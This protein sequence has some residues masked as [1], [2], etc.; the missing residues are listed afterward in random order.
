MVAEPGIHRISVTTLGDLLDLRAA[1]LGE[2]LAL[3]FP[4]QQVSYA[5]LAGRADFFARGLLAAGL[6]PGETVGI[7]LPNCVDT[8]A[9]LF[10]AAK[11]GLYPVPVN[12]RY[13]SLEL[14]GLIRHSRMRALFISPPDPAS[15]AAPD[16][17]ACW[18]RRSRP[19][20]A[21]TAPRWPWI[22]RRIYARSSSW[23]RAPHPG[24]P[25]RLTS[26]PPGPPCQPATS[27]AA[28]SWSKSATPSGAM[29]GWA[30]I[31]TMTSRI[32]RGEPAKRQQRWHWPG[33]S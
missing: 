18:R 30:A 2:H 19:W 8:I 5:G 11:A 24:S 4:D 33:E 1:E 10:G 17:P 14:A 3:V 22:A 15:P 23:A 32:A 21:R 26:P 9:A 16:F 6:R 27:S 13:K 7:L 29:I 20:Q 31:T 25:P 12:A 28:A